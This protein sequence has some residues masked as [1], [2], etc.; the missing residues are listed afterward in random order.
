MF[1]GRLRVLVLVASLLV[2]ALVFFSS[3]STKT[4]GTDPE[5][6]PPVVTIVNVPPDLSHFTGNPE[7]FWFG[8]DKDG[9]IIAYEY[10][11]IRADTLTA[12]GLI[13]SDEDSAALVDYADTCGFPWT[14]VSV[15]QMESN[16]TR[17]TIRLYAESDPSD[18]VFQV[19]FVRAMDDDSARSNID[20]RVYSRSNNPPDTEIRMGSVDTVYWDLEDTTENYKGI[21]IQWEGSDTIDYPSELDNPSFEFK[22][23]LYGPYDEVDINDLA[24]IVAGDP[25]KLIMTAEDTATGSPWLTDE[26]IRVFNLWR[27]EPPTDTTR[28]GWFIAVV[29]ARDDAF[30]PDETPAYGAFQAVQPMF[31]K[32]LLVQVRVDCQPTVQYGDLWCYDPKDSKGKYLA[33]IDSVFQAAG[34]GDATFLYEGI[35][36]KSVL[37]RYG[38][39]I[40]FS[41]GSS[42]GDYVSNTLMEGLGEYM[43]MGG[44]VWIWAPS[45][46]RALHSGDDRKLMG[47]SAND[48]PFK[49]FNVQ[50]EYYPAWK[51]SYSKRI[52]CILNDSAFVPPTDEQFIGG[53]AMPGNGFSDFTVDM[54]KVWIYGTLSKYPIQF[55]GAPHTC[56]LVKDVFS[57]PL[58]LINS[59]YG[60]FL[61]SELRE[62]NDPMQGK[63]VALRYET[64][65][66]KT[67]VFGFSFWMINGED[68]VD[69]VVNMMEWFSQ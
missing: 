26:E 62:Y 21:L 30:V 15:G 36:D 40:L 67:A 63:V 59:Y 64:K 28:A 47:F 60:T 54:D 68:A 20:Y 65:Y 55:V 10:I 37:G 27:N 6:K 4:G 24:A 13:V 1:L 69:M 43:D 22:F 16:P 38:N 12:H 48:I 61:P 2:S 50:M 14:T 3:C 46:F 9:Y 42:I 29:T 39:C 8:T 32:E 11:V 49:Y 66:F 34:Y 53:L 33:L 5:N 18:S 56:Y 31:E 7:I 51:G 23:Q 17:Q 25:S 58:Y 45:P 57:E 19:F 41:D 44:N 52:A 35:P